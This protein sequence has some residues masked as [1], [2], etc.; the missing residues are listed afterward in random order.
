M[1]NNQY[2]SR[3]INHKES[4]IVAMIVMVIIIMIIPLPTGIMDA[5]IAFN[6]GISVLVLMVVIYMESPLSLTAFPSILLILTLFRIGITVSTSR[7]ILL[8]ADAGKIVNT[9]GQFVVHGNLVVGAIIFAIITL[10]N[11]IVITKGSERVAEVAARFSLD[12]MPG[13]QMSI[14]S[15]LRAGNITQE[16]ANTKRNDL[17]LESKLYG[18]M[19]GAIKFV[20]GDAIASIVAIVI[21]LFGGVMVGLMIHDMNLT[22]AVKTYSL[23]TI[24]DGLVQQIPT[25]LVSL[26]AGMMVTQVSGESNKSNLGN[27]ILNQVFKSYKPLIATGVVIFLLALIPG[28]P[29]VVLL[30]ILGIFLLCAYFIYSKTKPGAQSQSETVNVIEDH[31]SNNMPL[32][33]SSVKVL[34]LVLYLSN[35]LKSSPN[36]SVI[37]ESLSKTQYEI[38]EELGVVLPHVVIAYDERLELNEYQLIINEIPAVKGKFYWD[39][40]LLLDSEYREVLGNI[41]LQRNEFKF[42]NKEGYFID[43]KHKDKCEEFGLQYYS[44]NEFLLLHL[45]SIL[46]VYVPDFLGLQEVKNML[47]K[48][49]DYQDLIRELVRYLP[50]NKIAEILKR[51]VMEDISIRNFKLILD[52]LF[53]WVQREKEVVILTEYVRKSLGRYIAYKFSN[54]SYLIS[55][56]LLSENLEDLIR[57]SIRYTNNGSYLA[58][59]TDHREQIISKLKEHIEANQNINNLAIVTQMDVRRYVKFVIE[60]ELPQINV[61]SFQE[62]EDYCQYNNIGIIGS[63]DYEPNFG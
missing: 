25:L 61:L 54:G 60:K 42:N 4:I 26:T 8:D 9:F 24:G 57:Q 16:Q 29:S 62:L 3:L 58:L 53:E 49:Q 38:M 39:K 32:D 5:L 47:D 19:D 21:N 11:F 56:I 41:E 34:P 45:R 43:A 52:G 2:L 22:T 63:D 46:R 40:I 18:A 23:L 12:A 14:D 51:L 31:K 7:L 17:G 35:Q 44:Y 37:K 30:I 36:L 59:D 27:N 20:K 1:L 28:M 10:I 48:F 13:K 6:L 55:A 33:I 15:D 50:I